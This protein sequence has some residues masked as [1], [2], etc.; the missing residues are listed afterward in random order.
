M[1][2]TEF[3]HDNDAYL[4][5]VAEHAEGFVINIQR[6]FN[7]SDART[8]RASCRWIRGQPPRGEGFTGAYIK[9]C[10]ESLVELSEWARLRVWSPIQDCG[11]CRPADSATS[12]RLA[13]DAE[14]PDRG[15][16]CESAGGVAVG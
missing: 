6:S 2:V 15:A 13:A 4:R 10:S 7:P 12:G 14:P 3:W 16:D 5:W 1:G 11:T 9:I 8:H